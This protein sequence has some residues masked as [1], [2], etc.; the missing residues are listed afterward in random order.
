MTLWVLGFRHPEL[1]EGSN[2]GCG[3]VLCGKWRIFANLHLSIPR[4]AYVRNHDFGQKIASKLKK[5]IFI[6][7]FFVNF[8]FAAINKNI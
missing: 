1:A 3:G 6:C 5:C 7:E 2:N 8:Y 4:G